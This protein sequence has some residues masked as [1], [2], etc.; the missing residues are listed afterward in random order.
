MMKKVQ[1]TLTVVWFVM[2]PVALA[3]GW[4]YSIAFVSACSIYANA[5]VH[6]G[7]LQAKK[8]EDS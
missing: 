6:W 8:A 4:I 5:A 2:V 7:A 1:I 3:T